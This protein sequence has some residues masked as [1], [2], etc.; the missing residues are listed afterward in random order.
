HAARED[1]A[2]ESPQLVGNGLVHG[3]QFVSRRNLRV[4]AGRRFACHALL[5]LLVVRIFAFAGCCFEGAD[6]EAFSCF[7]QSGRTTSLGLAEF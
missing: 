2:A 4:F 7:E 3:N 6:V 1:A 5:L